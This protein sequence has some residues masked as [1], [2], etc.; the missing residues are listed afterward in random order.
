MYLS[1]IIPCYNEQDRLPTTLAAIKNYL[2]AQAYDY[3]VIVVDNGSTDQ[4]RNIVESFV[5]LLPSL[6]IVSKKSHGKGW[7][8]KQGMLEAT[9]ELRLFT[10]ADNSTD[11]SQIEKLLPYINEGYDVVISSRRLPESV[12]THPSPKFRQ[13]LSSLFA[14]VVSLI[15]PTGVKDTQN[16]FKLFTK[17]AAESIFPQ[18]AIYYW[19]FDVEILAL[20]RKFGFKIKEVPIVWVNDERSRMNV[21]GMI[22]MIFEVMLARL[23]LMTRN[24]K[25]H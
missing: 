16:G 15:L 14:F 22:R 13:F 2:S 5:P 11:I 12:L 4:T 21:K 25:K 23:N 8:V 9:G 1:I 7:A 18:Q 17:K 10:D 20:A 3:E 19:A 24:Y 6:R